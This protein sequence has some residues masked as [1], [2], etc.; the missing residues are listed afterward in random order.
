[1]SLV[2]KVSIIMPVHNAGIHLHK[3]LD[4]L[5]NQTLK[6]IEIIIVLDCPTDGSEQICKQYASIDSRI[7]ILENESNLHVGLSRNEGLKVA[8]GEYIGFSDHDDFR[9]LDMYECLYNDALLEHSDVVFS[10]FGYVRNGSVHHDIY[11]SSAETKILEILLGREK[12]TKEWYPF[13]RNGGIWNKIY[14]RSLI[15]DNCLTFIDNKRATLEDLLF[16]IQCFHFSK[17]VSCVNRVFYYHVE[18]INNTSSGYSYYNLQF[19][20]EY[21]SNL[22]LFLESENI[23]KK[24]EY[25]YWDTVVF[26]T[27]TGILNEFKFKKWKIFSY[28]FYKQLKNNEVRSAFKNV[29]I[30]DTVFELNNISKILFA[31]VLFFF[32]K[33]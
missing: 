19:L 6:E 8:I 1:M 22:K 28:T 18:N 32:L 15:E 5:V 9:E 11:P 12:E 7:K 29:K 27:V 33:K 20:N 13:I 24:Y 4:S 2:P 21:C 26:F 3:C 14:K 17:N 10:A 25:R 31:K 23:Y 30:N 16:Q